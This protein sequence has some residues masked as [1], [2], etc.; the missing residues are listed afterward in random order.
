[1]RTITLEEHFTTPMYVEATQALNAAQPAGNQMQAL[2]QKLADLGDIRLRDMDEA[3]IDLQVLSLSGILLDRL[4]TQTA[5]AVAQNANNRAAEAV[6]ARPD[7]FAAFAALNLQEPEQAATELRRCIQELGFCGALVSGTTKGRFLDDLF[8]TPL[9]EAA[10]ELDAP[11]YLHPAPPPRTVQE[12]Y[13]KGLPDGF[14]QAL[15][16]A[17][18]GWHAE[19][20]LH[21]LRLI[22]SGLFDRF[23][24]LQIIIGHMGENLP[25]SMARADSV[26]PM[27]AQPLPKSVAEYFRSNIHVTTSGYFTMPPFLC[28]LQ[29]IGAD[30]LL[31]S[32]DYPYSPNTRGRAFLDALAVSPEDREKIAHG[33]AERLLKLPSML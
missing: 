32:V 14:G 17:A 10:Q 29:T 8:F 25:F 31:F 19:T 15:S 6:R 7:R 4:D 1:M 13:Y 21:V 5:T 2:E 22:V 23:P 24:R 26:L 12:A 28:A 11:I 9:F 3:G 27:A 16:I 33:N 20:G 30:R 18:W